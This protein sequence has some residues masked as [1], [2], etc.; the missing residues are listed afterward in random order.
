MEWSE[1]DIISVYT[2]E[3]AI[4]DGIIFNAG[5]I[6]NRDVDLT[7]NLIEKLD[8]YELAKA[9]VTALE[10]ARHFRQPDMKEININGKRV[11]VDDNGSVITL[12]LPEDY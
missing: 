3:D 7:A 8:K 4:E 10:I 5:R 6:A 2:R 12:M 1:E 11:W 9:I